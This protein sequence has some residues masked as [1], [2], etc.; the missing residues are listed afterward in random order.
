LLL[1]SFFSSISYCGRRMRASLFRR[2]RVG[3][4]GAVAGLAKARVLV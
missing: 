1:V 2:G 4:I 3:R